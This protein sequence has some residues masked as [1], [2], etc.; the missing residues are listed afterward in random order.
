M[1][2]ILGLIVLALAVVVA[3]AGAVTNT[4][5]AHALTHTFTVFGYHVTG[6]TG[7]LFLYG[8]AVGA[9]AMLGLALLLTGARR[10][11]R[12]AA[13]ARHGLQQS[14]RETDA[15][16]ADRDDLIQQRD[17]ARAQSA[18]TQGSQAPPSDGELEPGSE[19]RWPHLFGHRPVH[20]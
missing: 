19:R 6:S 11:S 10:T 1:I 4:G 15:A 5:S 7:T 12:R 3:V 8:I 9:V 2:I 13:A 17:S 18:G 14:R 16:A 20:R